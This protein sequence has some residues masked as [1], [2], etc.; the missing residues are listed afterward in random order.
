MILTHQ[1]II[2]HLRN[3]Y[4]NAKIS[5]FNYL[6]NYQPDFWQNLYKTY[7]THIFEKNIKS[8]LKYI[9]YLLKIN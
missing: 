6:E 8:Y 4:I 5:Y 7:N 9:L 3:N 1:H 2:S